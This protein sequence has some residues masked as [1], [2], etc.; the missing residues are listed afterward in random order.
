M[1]SIVGKRR[2]ENLRKKLL[3]KAIMSHDYA[4]YLGDEKI[5]W[6]RQAYRVK[7]E[8]TDTGVVCTPEGTKS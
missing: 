7:T 5:D 6:M 3:K 1:F 2:D 4:D 8:E